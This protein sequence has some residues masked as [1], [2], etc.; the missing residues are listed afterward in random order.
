MTRGQRQI[1]KNKP[2]KARHQRNKIVQLELYADVV[3]SAQFRTGA[4][5]KFSKFDQFCCSYCRTF[6]RHVE[7]I[8]KDYP[9]VSTVGIYTEDTNTLLFIVREHISYFRR[10][11]EVMRTQNL[12]K[13][14]G[15]PRITY[16]MKVMVY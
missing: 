10:G 2:F 8:R 11:Q 4:Q 7:R 9:S 6:T 3:L 16:N 12:V 14:G 13:R 15:L 1:H 5:Q